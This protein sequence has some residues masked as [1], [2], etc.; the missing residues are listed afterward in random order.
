[1]FRYL[2]GKP[3]FESK[4]FLREENGKPD[5]WTEKSRQNPGWAAGTAGP[6]AGSPVS[7]SSAP[8]R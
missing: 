3:K 1:M 4:G 8:L 2:E 6:G 7:A 5:E